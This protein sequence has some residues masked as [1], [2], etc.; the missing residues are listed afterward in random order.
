MDPPT[1]QY[2]QHW[3]S[4]Y[5]LAT[6]HACVNFTFIQAIHYNAAA[7]NYIG[8]AKV[9]FQTFALKSLLPFQELTH[10]SLDCLT[11]QD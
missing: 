2:T 5:S 10:E 3:V 11:H 4:I 7:D 1:T 6:D 8:F 9:N